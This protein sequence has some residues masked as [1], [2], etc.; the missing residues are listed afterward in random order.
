MIATFVSER[1][2]I[3]HGLEMMHIFDINGNCID[4]ITQWTLARSKRRGHTSKFVT[5]VSKGKANQ[6][7]GQGKS[8]K[9]WM[10]VT[11]A[12]ALINSLLIF[13]TVLTVATP[14]TTQFWCMLSTFGWNLLDT[15]IGHIGWLRSS[16]IHVRRLNTAKH[17]SPRTSDCWYAE[18]STSWTCL[19]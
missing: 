7:Q 18:A 13:F 11:A 5:L 16:H 15:F 1:G 14:A 12:L 10:K 9:I 2:N 4:F 17:L 6:E 19:L 8:W 3:L